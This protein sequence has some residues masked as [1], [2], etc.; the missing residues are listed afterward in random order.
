MPRVCAL[1]GN[2]RAEPPT[3]LAAARQVGV[4][5]LSSPIVKHHRR[6]AIGESFVST[7]PLSPIE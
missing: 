4:L 3:P 7:L 6:F 2:F 5:R 1:M